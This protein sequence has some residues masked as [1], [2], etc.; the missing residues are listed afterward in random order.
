MV[1]NIKWI[2][3]ALLFL[4]IGILASGSYVYFT[5]AN[6]ASR[7][8]SN[9]TDNKKILDI[10]AHV[11]CPIASQLSADE[12]ECYV[13][14]QMH[15]NFKFP[16]YLKAFAV[17]E[18]ELE[19]EPYKIVENLAARLRSS[20]YVG[21]AVLL[22]LDGWVDPNVGKMDL[23]KT[24]FFV[25]NKF[26]KSAVDRYKNEGLFYYGASINPHRPD[27]IERLIEA[28][29]DGAVLIKWIPSNM[30]I[31]PSDVRLTKFYEKMKELDIP[32]LTH[33]GDENT[34]SYA[35]NKLNDPLRLTLPLD[36]GVKV[37][38]AHV[39]TSGKVYRESNT[40]R[41]LRLFSNKK[42][43]KNLVAEISGTTQ[44]NRVFRYDMF[45]SNSNL[46]NRLL[47]GTD[48][49]LIEADFYALKLIPYEYYNRYLKP[50]FGVS[51]TQQQ[52]AELNSLDS[53]FD[54]DVRLKQMLGA[55][56]AVFNRAEEFLDLPTHA[57]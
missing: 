1:K 44:F 46:K 24:E 9:L 21:K 40:A 56:P 22:A 5:E 35:D 41:L 8:P 37:I 2:K 36:I 57:Q 27:A 19:L 32:L 55:D 7:E 29:K 16:V 15:K 42:Y 31:D 20:K 39:A 23:D 25:P 34:F 13:S 52:I 17:T 51:L 14:P 49:P 48:W 18:K 3:P 45:I 38:A 26:I 10:H 53:V 4:F 12:L 50:I 6:I 54:R 30:N 33:T 28:K 11:A 47:F 43:E